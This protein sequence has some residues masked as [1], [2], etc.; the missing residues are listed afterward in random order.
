MRNASYNK[1]K[2][3]AIIMIF[4]IF[5]SADWCAGEVV[6]FSYPTNQNAENSILLR[7]VSAKNSLSYEQSVPV[8]TYRR[9]AGQIVIASERHIE[10]HR[11]RHAD[12]FFATILF[13]IVMVSSFK[14]SLETGDPLDLLECH[15]LEFIHD[16]DGKKGAI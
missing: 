2:L 7:L 11:N 9:M 16:S 5:L 12:I 13:Q 6:G 3:F 10:R 14:L 15:I 1:I 8:E 4:A